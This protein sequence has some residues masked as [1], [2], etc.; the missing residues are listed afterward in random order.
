MLLK[1]HFWLLSMLNTVVLHNIFVETD[2]FYFS[3][4]TDQHLLE[5]EYM[6]IYMQMSW[7]GHTHGWWCSLVSASRRVSPSSCSS[8]HTASHLWRTHNT[9]NSVLA[10]KIRLHV[11][12]EHKTSHKGPFFRIEIHA[13]SESW[14]NH[15]FIDVWFGQYLKIW[16]KTIEILRKSSLKLFKWSS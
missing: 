5:M 4:F 10:S 11:T 14:I 3:W 2:A 6:M 7:S 13:S 16:C 1:K 12:L 15:I 9:H 8:P